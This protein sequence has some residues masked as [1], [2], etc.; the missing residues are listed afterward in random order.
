MNVFVRRTPLIALALAAIAALVQPREARAQTTVATNPVGYLQLSCSAN[1]DTYVSI[2]FTQTPAY[3]GTIALISGSTVTV[4]GSTGWTTNQYANISGTLATTYY[5]LL[6][7][8][9]TDT[10]NGASYTVIASSTNAVTLNLN[11]DSISGVPQGSSIS[12]IPYWTLDTVFPASSA[13]ASFT[14]STGPAARSRGTE[15]LFPDDS[16]AGINNAPGTILNPAPPTSVTYYYYNGQWCNTGQDYSVNVGNTPI[17]VNGYFIIRSVASS[18]TLTAMGTVPLNSTVVPLTTQSNSQQ[19]NAVSVEQPVGVSLNNLGLIT[20]G[21]FTASAGSASRNI[22]DQLLIPDNTIP[23]I[24]K[25]VPVPQ[26]TGTLPTY[27]T[28]TYYYYNGAWRNSNFDNTIDCGSQLLQAGTGFTIR[29][30]STTTGTSA[31]WTVTPTY[32][33]N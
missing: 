9:G 22:A 5:A 6:T 12:I 7:G 25:S 19:D 4:S 3:V 14:P 1:T 31:T 27:A 17:P 24:N 16:D 32:S 13:G 21:A 2:P 15:I 26:Y 18:G 11:G 29:K 10:R 28:G 23:G 33:N 20:S 30:V 8:T